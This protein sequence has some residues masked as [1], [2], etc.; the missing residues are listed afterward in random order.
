MNELREK[1]KKIIRI[2][3]PCSVYRAILCARVRAHF[4]IIFNAIDSEM[5]QNV[6]NGDFHSDDTKCITK[7]I[8]Q[9]WCSSPVVLIR[10]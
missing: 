1:M 6:Q 7:Y 5:N 10:T 9:F 4:Y 3:V 2:C 8:R